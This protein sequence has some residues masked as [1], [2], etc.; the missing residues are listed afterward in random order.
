MFNFP[1]LQT[2]AHVGSRSSFEAK[3]RF[4]RLRWACLFIFS[5]DRSDMKLIFPVQS[6]RVQMVHSRVIRINGSVQ[7]AFRNKKT[8]KQWMSAISQCVGWRLRDMYRIENG[9]GSGASGRVFAGTENATGKRVA[10]KVISNTRFPYSELE[11]IET[12]DHPNIMGAIEILVGRN[13]TVVVQELMRH[14]DLSK[15]L[16]QRGSRLSERWARRMAYQL[17]LGLEYLQSIAIAHRDIKPGNIFVSCTS[18]SSPI[19]RIGDLGSAAY[20]PP[21]GEK[22]PN[23]PLAGTY[24]FM[25]PEIVRGEGYGPQVDMFSC[26]ATIYEMLTGKRAFLGQSKEE[27]FECILQRT[28]TPPSTLWSYGTKCIRRWSG[29]SSRQE[30]AWDN[31]SSEARDLV[32]RM[33]TPVASTR[34]TGEDALAHPWFRNERQ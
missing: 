21:D 7:L 19:L 10:L 2:F 15:V 31:L 12:M 1:N 17:L 6:T 18:S 16:A 9:I 28:A 3:A 11:I 22:Y 25:A 24:P 14:G 34:I 32:V 20:Y 29:F 4:I 13:H 23:P 30:M 5:Y 33:L 8:A 26:G 27:I